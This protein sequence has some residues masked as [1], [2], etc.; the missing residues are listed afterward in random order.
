MTQLTPEQSIARSFKAVCIA[1]LEA[2]KP[3]NVHIFADG[4]GMTVQDFVRSAEAAA[5][6]IAQPKLS[7][8]ERILLAVEAT[9]RAVGCN[10]NLGIILLCAPLVQAAL[11][12]IDDTFRERLNLV[13]KNL[14]QQDA[15]QTFAAI[16]IAAPAGLASSAQHDVNQPA[17]TT[18]LAAMRIAADRDLIARQYV[19]GYQQ[20]FSAQEIYRQLLQRWQRPAWAATGVYLY[21][22]AHHDDSHIMRKYGAATA[23]NVR[24]QATPYWQALQDSGNPKHSMRSLLDFDAALKSHSINPGTS[25]DLT[26]ATLLLERLNPEA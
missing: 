4:H 8:G 24:Q 17:S 13:L 16:R 21:V 7:V 9:H 12:D 5:K 22:M 25:A 15:E 6:V 26:V 14:T 2:L 11:L 10:T 1:E 20:V 19:N 18:L 23:E 3:G